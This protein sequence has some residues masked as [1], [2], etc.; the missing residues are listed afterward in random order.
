MPVAFH[1]RGASIATAR[2]VLTE[3]ELEALV[4]GDS[5]AP[6]CYESSPVVLQ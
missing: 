1:H 3:G 5:K 2:P 4:V 6:R